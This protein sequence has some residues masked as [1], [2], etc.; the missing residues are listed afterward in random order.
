M[1]EGRRVRVDTV[2]PLLVWESP[3][4]QR[5]TRR[6]PT[7]GLTCCARRRRARRAGRV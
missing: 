4:S 2:A 7:C 6:L 1:A 3:P 5:T